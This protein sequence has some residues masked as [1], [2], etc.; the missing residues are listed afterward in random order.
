M[1][2]ISSRTLI[3]S[4]ATLVLALG[5][6]L[7]ASAQL[8]EVINHTNHQWKYFWESDQGTTW[9]EVAYDDSVWTNGFG[10]FGND[11][12]VAAYP[13]FRTTV[14]GGTPVVVYYRTHFTWSGA[15]TGV[16]L[17]FTNWIDDGMVVYLNGQELFRY[18]LPDPPAEITFATVATAANPA[19]EGVPVIRQIGVDPSVLVAGDNVLAVS[20]HQ[21]SAT[22]SDHVFNMR[23]MSSQA[24]PPEFTLQP[25]NETVI[26]G[27]TVRLASLASGVPA[28]TYQW[29]HDGLPVD[30]TVNATANSSTLVIT[31]F[32]EADGGEYYVIAQSSAG[33]AESDHVT[34]TYN[35]DTFGPVPLRAF[36]Q[37]GAMQ[38]EVRFDE[39]LSFADTFNLFVA[40]TDD[41]GTPLETIGAQIVSETNLIIL[42]TQA[43]DPA[44]TYSVFFLEAAV[45]DI[46][47]NVNL[48]ANLPLSPRSL[49]QEGL[50]G[51]V[52]T[53]D[54]EI[55]SPTPDAA[56]GEDLGI[57]VD[58]DSGG[59]P[60]RGLLRFDFLGS[61]P[62]QVPLGANIISATL[63]VNQ[64]D[65]T[66]AGEAN[67][68]RMHRMLVAWDE[69]STWNSLV[70]GVTPDDVE[71]VVTPDAIVPN[72]E[73]TTGD[74]PRTMD[75]TATVQAWADGQPNFGWVFVP[76][77]GDGWDFET[78]EGATRPL[79]SVEYDVPPPSP[80]GIV[81]QP[82]A[83]ITRNERDLVNISIVV[84]G[85]LPRFQWFK[86]DVE[87]PGATSATLTISNA[88]P[89]DSGTY[90]V[91]VEND[92]PST[93]TSTDV[94]LMVTP[95][96]TAPT[97]V[98]AI[99]DANLTDITLVFSEPVTA[100]TAEDENNY[101]LAP[102]LA[103]SSAVLVN[104]TTVRLTTAARTFPDDY[105]LTVQNISDT[106][107][108]PNIM[109]PTS[110]TL[111]TRSARLVG[112]EGMW[113]YE[114]INDLHGAGW[115]NVTDDQIPTEGAGL[116]G[117]ESAGVIASLNFPDPQIRT[118]LTIGAAQPTYYFRK[119]VDLPPLPAGAIYAMR[120]AVD[121]SMVV[122]ID[123]TEAFRV[124][125]TNDTPAYDFSNVVGP[126]T[127]G[128]VECAQ[129]NTTAGSH[130]IDVE[131]HNASGTSS[132]ILFGAEIVMLIRPSLNISHDEGGVHVRWDPDPNWGLVSST[133]VAGPYALVTGN[134]VGSLTV[135]NQTG[136]TF[137]QLLC[138]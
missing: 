71:A 5:S 6:S 129:L 121:D 89:S 124:R 96:T 20:V 36:G 61:N 14:P 1:R 78:S 122:Y 10:S 66:A 87:I 45:A 31:N 55:Q 92:L 113:R 42:T 73:N 127:E 51:F 27:R 35:P 103:V 29:F 123:G 33:S 23:V 8:T 82:P 79:L 107:V 138:Q 2:L 126:P 101:S 128:T 15:T 44:E 12:G 19:G 99:G 63:T 24:V 104:P 64:T 56:P 100:A 108:T 84:T 115:P 40:P 25:T 106:A 95:D 102:A 4:F 75:V 119:T 50:N 69:S 65:G 120:F 34:L 54:T 97:L 9:K 114:E 16:I 93:V 116:F 21:N 3:L 76:Q 38:V 52:G 57:T 81:T 53:F 39:G 11:T 58:L 7:R 17:T 70:N 72:A 130:R 134:P 26:Q 118:A 48:E 135:T 22:S 137:Y 88:L 91:V 136:N 117:L 77:S 105:T 62:G 46:Y 111:H 37:P 59:G 133:N 68:P 109:G 18:N 28:P 32:M 110:V 43:L 47:G 49:F 94:L 74:G 131:V 60:T 112:H 98:N 30:V 85:S 13:P 83:S 80:I 132:D 41:P 67:F 125:Y 90:H 86:D